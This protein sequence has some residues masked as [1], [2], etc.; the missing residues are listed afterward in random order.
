MAPKPLNFRL[1]IPSEFRDTWDS[2]SNKAKKDGISP[3]ELLRNLIGEHLE[4]YEEESDEESSEHDEDFDEI[5]KCIS[6][7]DA[8]VAIFDALSKFHSADENCA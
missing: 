4:N 7:F 5:Q 2:F 3:A 8:D 1:S 6:D